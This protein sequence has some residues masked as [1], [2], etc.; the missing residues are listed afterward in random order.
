MFDPFLRA[1]SRILP[2]TAAVE[3]SMRETDEVLGRDIKFTTEHEREAEL[4]RRWAIQFR[5]TDLEAAAIRRAF[6][7]EPTT[8]AGLQAYFEMMKVTA[9]LFD[10]GHVDVLRRA[11][12]AQLSGAAR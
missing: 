7:T 12:T 3:A 10:K 5:W 11:V 2:Y 8:E 1:R 4:D 9:D 6:S